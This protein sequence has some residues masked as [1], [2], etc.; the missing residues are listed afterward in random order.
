MNERRS[1]EKDFAAL[2]KLAE[3]KFYAWHLKKLRPERDRR[4]RELYKQNL[5]TAGR[6]IE[7]FRIS[8]ELLEREV[9][10]RVGFYRQVARKW[11]SSE[12]LSEFRSRPALPW[13]EAAPCVADHVN[14]RVI[15]SQGARHSAD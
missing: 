5:T 1:N 10:K 6:A 15:R 2:L 4:L 8:R 12:M 11:R 7:A 3:S 13:Q 14:A 9:I